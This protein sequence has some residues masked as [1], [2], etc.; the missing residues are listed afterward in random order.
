VGEEHHR[1]LPLGISNYSADYGY[2]FI[3][4]LLADDVADRAEGAGGDLRDLVY[5][6]L[7]DAHDYVSA[8]E[9]LTSDE[10]WPQTFRSEW[11]VLV[12]AG[13]RRAMI[14]YSQDSNDRLLYF[15]ENEAGLPIPEALDQRVA[16]AI[17]WA[18]HTS[19]FVRDFP[20]GERPVATTMSGR[21][22]LYRPPVLDN[23]VP[24]TDLARWSRDTAA[25]F[26]EP[27]RA[28]LVPSAA[29]R[30]PPAPRPGPGRE[31]SLDEL[32][33]WV[34]QLVAKLV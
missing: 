3:V 1:P 27:E 28:R 24:H 21:L 32:Q 20:D 25:S 29:L 14:H 15:I 13:D 12:D 31:V 18:L 9:T 34:S 26:R 6:W 4:F 23:L 8:S 19:V 16:L 5:E 10:E 7:E 2:D 22:P 11:R 33:L 30:R 17:A